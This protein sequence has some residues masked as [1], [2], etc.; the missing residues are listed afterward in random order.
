MRAL[1]TSTAFHKDL[2]RVY[3]R[4]YDLRKLDTIIAKLQRGEVLPPPN[5]D[6]PLKGEWKGVPR[7]PYRAGLGADL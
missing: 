2:K 5:R 3:R 7:L 4:G 1:V 6:H